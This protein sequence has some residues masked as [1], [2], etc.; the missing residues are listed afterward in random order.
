MY[1]YVHRYILIHIF[2]CIYISI[3]LYICIFPFIYFHVN[4]FIFIYIYWDVPWRS[5]IVSRSGIIDFA[6]R[7]WCDG[8]NCRPMP[9]AP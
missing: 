9:R 6:F 5:L 4:M 7:T 8:T 2:I 3:Y 1:V